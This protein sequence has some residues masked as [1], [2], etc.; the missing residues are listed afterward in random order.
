MMGGAAGGDPFAAMMGAGGG[1]MPP[2]GPMAML[3]NPAMMQ[4][5]T[6]MLQQVRARVHQHPP[7]P[8][9]PPHHASPQPGFLEMI[10]AQNPMLGQ[11]LAQPGMREVMR[12]PA[13]LQSLPALMAMQGGMGGGMPGMQPGGGMGGGMPAGAPAPG[14]MGG[15]DMASLL[16]GMGGAPPAPAA[17]ADTRPPEERFAAGLAQMREMGFTD[18]AVSL[19]ALAATA[20]NVQF[21]ID[22]ILDGRV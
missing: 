20:G 12:S 15:F 21:A 18:D 22:R 11:M 2:G 19:R 17:P 9:S 1:G 16:A 7:S 4:M 13:F 8:P 3:Q 6:G 10:E 14:G 5:M